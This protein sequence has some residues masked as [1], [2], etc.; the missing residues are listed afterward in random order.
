MNMKTLQQLIDKFLLRQYIND[1]EEVSA[2]EYM[3][4]KKEIILKKH[5]SNV[6]PIQQMM[7]GGKQVYYTKLDPSNRNHSHLI[8]SVDKEDL[9]NKIIAYYLNI[10]S[11][12]KLTVGN[13]L[14]LTIAELSKETSKRHQQRFDKHI[15]TL[16]NVKISRLTIDDIRTALQ[17]VIELGIEEKEFNNLTSTLNKI[18]DYCAYNRIDC[19]NIRNA[20]FEFRKYRLVGKHVFI[21][22]KIADTELAFSE[23]EA[24]III[25]YAIEHPDYHNLAIA[26]LILTGLRAGEILALTPEDVNLA[27][28][29]LSVTKMEK[30]HSCQIV[31]YCKEHSERFVYLND[32]A[33]KI[34]ELLM[35]KRIVDVT[36][37]PY[38]ILNHKAYEDKMHLGPLDK[39]IRRLQSMLGFAP[40]N[41]IRS[42]H[43]CRRTYASIQ[44]LHGVDIEE[45]RKQLGHKTQQQTWEYI[46]DIADT[47]TRLNKLS[48]GCILS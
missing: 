25:K 44:Y 42:C 18:H 3:T 20:I 21:S 23:S 34:F 30:T 48:K 7:K 28:H 11:T 31:D 29:K 26:A 8:Y 33:M 9:E 5:T 36:T 38:L 32:D 41:G 1:N 47:E 19:I 37:C 13:I 6:Y 4:K 16:R 24:L 27:A 45:I 46:K 10:E 2:E 14:E 43:D 22:K 15:S 12:N 39:R 40:E 35:E 17:H